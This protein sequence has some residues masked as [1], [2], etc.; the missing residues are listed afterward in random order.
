MQADVDGDGEAD[1]EIAVAGVSTL[2][3]DDFVLL[4]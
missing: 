3:E 1:M 2:S 4:S